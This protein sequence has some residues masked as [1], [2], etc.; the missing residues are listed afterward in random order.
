MW[1]QS[2]FSLKILFHP[3][4]GMSAVYGK[5]I[6]QWYNKLK[7]KTPRSCI[8]RIV[9]NWRDEVDTFKRVRVK[10][11][12][13]DNYTLFLDGRKEGENKLVGP[14]RA[15]PTKIWVLHMWDAL[16][17]LPCEATCWP[18]KSVYLQAEAKLWYRYIF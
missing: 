2:C 15:Y 13:W 17:D 11:R 9:I 7:E 18:I 4:L 3:T 14:I 5:H 1:Y 8:L 16:C 12:L 10:R 6:L